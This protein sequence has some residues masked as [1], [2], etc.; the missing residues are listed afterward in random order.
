MDFLF[1][2]RPVDLSL[3]PL[4]VVTSRI[5][6]NQADEQ[7]GRQRETSKQISFDQNSTVVA[8]AICT[9]HSNLNKYLSRYV[10]FIFLL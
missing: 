2:W 7:L 4:F 5:T 6:N 9:I 8:F 3:E 1:V 10:F